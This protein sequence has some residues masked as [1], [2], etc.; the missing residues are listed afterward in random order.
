M[1]TVPEYVVRMYGEPGS[2]M[3]TA[4]IL[5]DDLRAYYDLA[6]VLLCNVML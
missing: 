2:D 6:C 5:S 3:V 1:S 4:K